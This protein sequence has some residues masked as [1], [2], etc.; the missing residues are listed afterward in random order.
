MNIVLLILKII[1]IVLLV[2]I[3][4]ILLVLVL[5]VFCPVTYRINVSYENEIDAKVKVGWL[6]Y[7]ITVTLHYQKESQKCI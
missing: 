6:F 7:L 2:L 3:G 4:L 5:V 1:G